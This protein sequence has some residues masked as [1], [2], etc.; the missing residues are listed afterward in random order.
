MK[1]LLRA[2]LGLLPRSL[3]LFYRSILVKGKSACD[4]LKTPNHV[5]ERTRSQYQS[6]TFKIRVGPKKE[7][8][9]A[10]SDVL[11]KSPK[12]DKQCNGGF[13]EAKKKRLDLDHDPKIFA[14][15]LEFLYTGILN[16]N[17]FRGAGPLTSELWTI[18]DYWPFRGDEFE[19]NRSEDEDV[20]ATQLQRWVYQMPRP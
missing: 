13:E 14:L 16:V 7:V 11:A 6:D 2:I 3:C 17:A 8:F 1:S 4:P 15:L 20:R 12:L 10:H 19:Q 18:G 9:T 5:N